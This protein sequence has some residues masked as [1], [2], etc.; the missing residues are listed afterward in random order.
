M[1]VFT[2]TLRPEVAL[3][4]WD[5]FLNEGSKV[6]F[7][8]AI[9]LFKMNEVKILAVRDAGDLFTTL[10][11]IG[12][13]VLDADALIAAAYRTYIPPI[14]TSAPPNPHVAPYTAA[15][16][17][18]RLRANSKKGQ[19]QTRNLILILLVFTI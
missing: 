18:P 14:L 15:G 4:V 7:R 6:L 13:D 10:R 11:E 12:K 2:N 19:V 3:R 9:S 8:I 1:C 5:I 17:H 16:G